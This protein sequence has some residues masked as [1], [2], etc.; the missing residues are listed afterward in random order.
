[1]C[2]ASILRLWRKLIQLLLNKITPHF[3]LLPMSEVDQ[4]FLRI[5]EV[6]PLQYHKSHIM[7]YLF[8]SPVLILESFVN[9]SSFFQYVFQRSYFVFHI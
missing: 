3:H 7:H 8:L 1:M 4:S 2:F 5:H 9:F 6:S